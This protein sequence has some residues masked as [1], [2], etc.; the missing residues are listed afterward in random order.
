MKR[1]WLFPIQV[2]FSNVFCEI[3]L[4]FSINTRQKRINEIH[5]SYVFLTHICP[6]EVQECS[7]WICTLTWTKADAHHDSKTYVCNLCPCAF[8]GDFFI[9]DIM[10][11]NKFTQVTQ[12]LLKPFPETR[13]FDIFDGQVHVAASTRAASLKLPEPVPPRLVAVS[14]TK[15]VEVGLPFEQRNK[16]SYFP[17]YWWFDRDPY[18]GLWNTPF[19][20]LG[21]IIT[22]ITQ[23]TRVFFLAHLEETWKQ[24][25]LASDQHIPHKKYKVISLL[26]FHW[27]P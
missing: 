15:P 5:I 6:R 21:S 19:L 4:Q 1:W 26:R 17:L 23:P 12:V 22:Y 8:V 27:G 7:K 9:S 2:F 18:N 25:A 24:V 3:R 14:K 20:L 16:A 10:P 13:N 11:E